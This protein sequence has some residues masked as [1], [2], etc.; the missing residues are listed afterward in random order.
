MLRVTPSSWFSWNFIVFE[1]DD[2]VADVR[3]AVLREAG[4]LIVRGKA[5]RVNREGIMSGAFILREGDL[6]LARAEKPSAFHRSFQVDHAGRNYVLGAESAV[7]RKFVLNENGETVGSVSPLNA[8]T[9]KC[10]VDLP[11]DIPLPVRVFMIWLVIILW[12]RD[13]DTAAVV[14]AG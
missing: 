12:K 14:A 10:L 8:F 9:R 11:V 7:R 6:E 13:S 4:E 5:Y 2:Q 3:L 1:G